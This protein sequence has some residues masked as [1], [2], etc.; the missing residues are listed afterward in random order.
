MID[1]NNIEKPNVQSHINYLVDED[2]IIWVEAGWDSD[3]E[4]VVGFANL[5]Y[6]LHSGQLM[7]ES[8]EFIKSRCRTPVQKRQYHQLLTTL[9][10]LF[11]AE[12]EM[13]EHAFV[14][15]DKPV[16]SPTQVFP[17]YGSE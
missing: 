8:L 1:K 4:S 3:D 10:D 12:P 7:A 11:F 2:G 9:N 5:L 14:Q 17:Q 6:E 15:S 13:K 16:V